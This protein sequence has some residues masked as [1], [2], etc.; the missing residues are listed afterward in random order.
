MDTGQKILEATEE[1]CTKMEPRKVTLDMVAAKAKV[2]KGTIYN[3]FSSKEDLL[4]KLALSLIEKIRT[5]MIDAGLSSSGNSID[6]LEHLGTV[7]YEFIK[8]HPMLIAISIF[9]RDTPP[10]MV[11]G[12]Q[13]DFF[14][15]ESLFVSMIDSLVKLGVEEGLI[16]SDL[17]TK[18]IA[19]FM[20][21]VFRTRRPIRGSETNIP[22]KVIRE[23][24]LNGA[25]ADQ[26]T[27]S[28]P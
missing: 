10:W 14:H 3:H 7:F 8:K 21:S 15:I 1:I 24:M 9:L 17:D 28:H 6:R 12:E 2:G 27:P 26:R 16:R 20:L 19:Y 11:S 18:T 4:Q 23:L 22:D 5:E 25:G 13:D